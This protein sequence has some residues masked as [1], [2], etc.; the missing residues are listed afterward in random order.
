MRIT[1]LNQLE[2]QLMRIT[3]LNQLESQLHEDYRDKS[4]REPAAGGLPG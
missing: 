2:S 3:G 1:R 4:V